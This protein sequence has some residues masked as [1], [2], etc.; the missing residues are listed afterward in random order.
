MATVEA[1]PQPVEETPQRIAAVDDQP[2]AGD[3][4]L[5]RTV[6]EVLADNSVASALAEGDSAETQ[7]PLSPPKA[8]ASGSR[9]AAFVR[10][11]PAPRLGRHRGP[12]VVEVHRTDVGEQAEASPLDPDLQDYDL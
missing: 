5:E 1:E 9:S 2:F 12:M 11:T 3:A 10:R 8:S 6:Q 4:Q 7:R